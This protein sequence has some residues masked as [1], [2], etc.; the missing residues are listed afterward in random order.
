MDETNIE[1]Y[2]RYQNNAAVP[3]DSHWIGDAKR[4]KPLKTV[5]HLIAACVDVSKRQLLGLPDNHGP[6]TLHTVL[7][8]VESAA[9]EPDVL[10]STINAGRAV[11]TALLIKSPKADMARPGLERL[12]AFIQRK[13]TEQEERFIISYYSSRVDLIRSVKLAIELIQ[14]IER[15]PHSLT[16]KLLR[17]KEIEISGPFNSGTSSRSSLL[18]AFKSGRPMLLKIPSP[19]G[20]EK[21]YKVWT[22]LAPLAIGA[23][24]L[25]H[26]VGP[27]DHVLFHRNSDAT[28]FP[29]IESHATKAPVL[30]SGILMPIYPACLEQV[31]KPVKE[32]TALTIWNNMNVALEAMHS[33][34]LCHADVK[35]PNIF[36]DMAGNYFPGDYGATAAR[37][38][39]NLVVT[40]GRTTQSRHSKPPKELITGC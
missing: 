37:T 30:R 26:L 35:S 17:E 5:G 10:L 20:V 19:E 21:E 39:T 13:L 25:F 27:M 23:E 28:S 4:L 15:L 32:S 11:R 8:C 40:T 1:L 31:P 38:C 2:V 6:L 36:I 12:E 33:T 18:V 7:E 16:R 29:S 3:I 22:Q 14:E 9:L 24:D 34:G